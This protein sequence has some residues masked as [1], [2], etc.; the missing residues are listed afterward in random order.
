MR[1]RLWGRRGGGK[2]DERGGV[3]FVE[4]KELAQIFFTI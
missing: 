1:R 4:S 3:G 2:G